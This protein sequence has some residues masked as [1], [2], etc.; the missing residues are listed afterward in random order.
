M[1]AFSSDAIPVHLLTREAFQ[2]Y[3]AKLA[4]KG[5]LAVHITNRHLDLVPVTWT[6]ARHFDLAYALVRDVPTDPLASRSTWVLL[7]RDPALLELPGIRARAESMTGYSTP[8]RLWTDDWSN[9]F[10]ILK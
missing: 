8:L 5:L 4:D 1:D 7:S 3:S 9:L 6:L 10:Q 2:L